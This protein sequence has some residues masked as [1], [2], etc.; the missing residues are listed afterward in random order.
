[1]KTCLDCRCDIPDARKRCWECSRAHASKTGSRR[2]AGARDAEEAGADKACLDCRTAIP[3]YR[4]RCWECSRRKTNSRRCARLKELR[5]EAA[6]TKA[7]V[8]RKT[9]WALEQRC[10]TLRKRGLDLDQIAA[11]VDAPRAIVAK[12]LFEGLT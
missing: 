10:H 9:R 6:E 11:A 12:A 2:R 8:D 5:V 3:I 7:R 1:M 4:K